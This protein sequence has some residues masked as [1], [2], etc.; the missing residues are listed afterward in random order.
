MNKRWNNIKYWLSNFPIRPNLILLLALVAAVY[1]LF[2]KTNPN[3]EEA[4][5]N[6]FLPLVILLSKAGII[7]LLSLITLSIVSTIISFLVY[8]YRRKNGQAGFQLNLANEEKD[9]ILSIRP[10]L[11][12]GLRP[13][14]GY[15][16]GTLLLNEKQL[17]HTF[18][19]AS[20]QY[21]KNSLRTEALYG[22]AALQFP[23]IKE[24]QV[25]GTML[26]FEDMLR[27]IRL[28][29][30][31]PLQKSFVNPPTSIINNEPEIQALST[32]E[33]DVRI[34]QMRNVEGEFLNYKQFEYGDDVRR[35]VWKI[36]GKNRELIV[37]NPEMRNP[38]ASRIEMY[39]SFHSSLPSIVLNNKIGNKLLNTYKNAVWSLYQSLAQK[40]EWELTYIPEHTT[41]NNIEDQN[42]KVA[43]QI[44]QSDWQNHQS[45]EQY[46]NLK[47][48][49][50]FCIHSLTNA[51]ALEQFL[52][53]GGA[54]K[55]IYMAYLS[56]AFANKN[57]HWLKKIFFFESENDDKKAS[58]TSWLLS[59]LKNQI[60]KNEALLSRILKA[61]G[62]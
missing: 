12:K 35:I 57:S 30:K 39:A 44:A 29:A 26:Y 55:F 6:S 23:D 34:E 11:Q 13:L 42:E 54:D 56:D 46:F 21:K 49:S 15:I 17:S 4:E 1:Y 52:D 48:G 5:M 40:Q 38:F 62:F 16:S 22:S 61:Y 18:V 31:E 3:K 20:T 7:I 33:M 10:S 14:L 8:K 32:K 50:V 28:S 9:N 60:L 37:R 19:L 59:P 36:Y 24:Y 41:L 47:K 58:Q 53:N 43:L 27:L 2:F 51:K 25:E 45:I